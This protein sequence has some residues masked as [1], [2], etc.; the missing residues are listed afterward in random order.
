M[1]DKHPR[2]GEHASGNS[3]RTGFTLI[4]LGSFTGLVGVAMSILQREGLMQGDP[5]IGST[6]MIVI[7]LVNACAGVSMLRVGT[8]QNK[9][10]ADSLL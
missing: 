7:S 1:P 9:R 8:N 5:F 3:R 4:A 6:G 2:D 10:S